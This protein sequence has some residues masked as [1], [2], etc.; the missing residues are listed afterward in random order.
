[1]AGSGDLIGSCNPL[2]NA[3]IPVNDDMQNAL[4]FNKFLLLV[5]KYYTKSSGGIL[6]KSIG[7]SSTSLGNTYGRADVN[8]E[9]YLR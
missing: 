3:F 4:Y 8:P 9:A 5:S 2:C 7:I 6:L 1:M